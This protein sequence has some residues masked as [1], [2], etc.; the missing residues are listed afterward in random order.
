MTENRYSE[1]VPGKYSALKY[2]WIYLIPY[3]SFT[4]DWPDPLIL[5]PDFTFMFPT[6]FRAINATLFM[7]VVVWASADLVPREARTSIPQ[8][9]T[10]AMLKTSLA[11]LR[12]ISFGT[13]LIHQVMVYRWKQTFSS[14]TSR[15]KKKTEAPPNCSH[16]GSCRCVMSEQSGTRL[17]HIK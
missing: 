4:N 3:T 17:L 5:I 15:E 1:S 10:D 16:C 6:E 2:M 9:I 11:K 14:C 13:F 8:W 7:P 12:S